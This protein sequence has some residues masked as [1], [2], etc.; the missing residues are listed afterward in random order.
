MSST[1]HVTN[2]QPAAWVRPLLLGVQTIGA[3]ILVRYAVPLYREMA[4]APAQHQLSR[5]ILVWTM[6]AAAM[7]QAAYWTAQ[8]IGPP[9][10]HGQV[11]LSHLVKFVG[12]VSF[13]ATIAIFSLVFIR[14]PEDLNLPLSR[15]L[16]LLVG[17]FSMFCYN[18]ELDRVGNALQR[19]RGN[20]ERP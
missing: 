7:L 19:P 20:H 4:G 10:W 6:G 5:S 9:P 18:L 14:R 16:G 3:G 8:R 1:P 15:L 2:C 12:R 17:V 13:M 11:L